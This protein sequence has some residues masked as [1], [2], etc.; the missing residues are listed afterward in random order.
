MPRSTPMAP[1]LMCFDGCCAQSTRGMAA[2]HGAR[3]SQQRDT[4][5][6]ASIAEGSCRADERYR[7][8][9][10]LS[11]VLSARLHPGAHQIPVKPEARGKLM[12]GRVKRVDR[13]GGGG[14]RRHG[15]HDTEHEAWS[16]PG[17]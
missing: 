14:H 7:A 5:W 6:Q 11:A 17:I 12:H 1:V 13:D 9:N 10:S 16:L 8:V 4:S 15:C 2:P 3:S